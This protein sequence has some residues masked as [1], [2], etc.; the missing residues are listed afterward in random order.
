MGLPYMGHPGRYGRVGLKSLFPCC[1]TI[2]PGRPPD[3][4]SHWSRTQPPGAT[5]CCGGREAA[6]TPPNAPTSCCS[7]PP[8]PG[9]ADAHGRRHGSECRVT[10]GRK[11]RVLWQARA[12][13][14]VGSVPVQRAIEG[15]KGLRLPGQYPRTL[16]HTP[17]HGDP[18]PAAS[19]SLPA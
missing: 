14:S 15:L 12:A 4:P 19:I 7:C 18:G 8:P 9:V 2:P 17:H 13:C 3:G 10:C 16:E 11:T 5:T 1:T 6:V